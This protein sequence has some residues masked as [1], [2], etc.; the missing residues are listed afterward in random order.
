MRQKRTLPREILTDAE[1]DALMAQCDAT[2]IGMR[3]RA[4][5]LLLEGT[6]CRISEVMAFAPRDFDFAEE[7]AN[8]RCGKGNKQRVVAVS[9]EA[10]VAVRAWLDERTKLGIATDAPV[11]C[12][13]RGKALKPGMARALLPTLAARAGIRKRVHPHG[14]RHRFTVRLVRHGVTLPS[15]SWVLGHSNIKITD[16]YCRRIGASHAIDDVRKALDTE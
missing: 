6:G 11:C 13:M 14:F 16:T 15:V 5:L 12:D 10:L 7:L 2:P 8:V 9:P 4:M 1:S 3:N